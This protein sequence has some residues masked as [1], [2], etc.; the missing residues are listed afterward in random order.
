[1]KS[2]SAM[3]ENA[4]TMMH[5]ELGGCGE[6]QTD[7]F[8]NLSIPWLNPY[9]AEWGNFCTIPHFVCCCFYCYVLIVISGMPSQLN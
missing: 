2:Y 1:M 5:S 9:A 7:F 3:N 6:E 8:N 4:N